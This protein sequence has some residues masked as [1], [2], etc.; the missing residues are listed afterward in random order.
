MDLKGTDPAKC[1]T[2]CTFRGCVP[3]SPVEIG[4]ISAVRGDR[5]CCL[6]ILHYIQRRGGVRECGIISPL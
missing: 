1:H 6:N 3:K 5:D 4:T 2:V